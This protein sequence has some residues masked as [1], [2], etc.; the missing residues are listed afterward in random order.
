MRPIGQLNF[1]HGRCERVEDRMRE[2]RSRAYRKREVELNGTRV[3]AYHSIVLRWHAS[4]IGIELTESLLLLTVHNQKRSTN[5][6]SCM[7]KEQNH[8]IIS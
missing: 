6:I 7:M 5:A 3:P 1:Q 8:T 4:R 2:F